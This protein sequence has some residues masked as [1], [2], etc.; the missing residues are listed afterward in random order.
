M[1]ANSL[2]ELERNTVEEANSHVVRARDRAIRALASDAACIDDFAVAR[3]FPDR[4]LGVEQEGMSK[5]AQLVSVECFLWK[6]LFHSPMLTF[7]CL[8]RRR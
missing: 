7:P 3:D 8:R 1:V 6:F 5:S 4:R 2:A